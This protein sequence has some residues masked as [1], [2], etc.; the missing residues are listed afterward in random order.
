[1]RVQVQTLRLRG[2]HLNR[3]ELLDFPPYLG[4]LKV[5]EARDPDLARPVVRAR[6][7]D[8]L[9]TETD[10][11]PELCDARLLWVDGQKLRLTGFE[12][13]EAVDYMQTWVVELA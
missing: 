5:A 6:L 12:R 3:D 8:T 9:G 7:I 2:R 13:I 4:S 11:L 1:M 10:V